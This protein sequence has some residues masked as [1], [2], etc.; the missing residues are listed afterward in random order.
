MHLNTTCGFESKIKDGKDHLSVY[1]SANVKCT[2]AN[3]IWTYAANLTLSGAQAHD[4]MVCAT[5]Y[6]L[7]TTYCFSIFGA[8]QMTCLF[9]I[10][11]ASKGH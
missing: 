2:S 10:I 3:V 7:F 8:T 4:S 6:G 1:K 9:N 5:K 11:I